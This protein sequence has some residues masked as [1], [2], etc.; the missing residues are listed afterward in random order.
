[1]KHCIRHKSNGTFYYLCQPCPPLHVIYLSPAKQR[2]SCDLYSN[3][4]IIL[5]Y[6]PILHVTIARGNHGQM[7][8]LGMYDVFS[9]LF[10]LVHLLPILDAVD[11]SCLPGTS[12]PLGLKIAF[13]VPVHLK[14]VLL[15][16][17]SLFAVFP[18]SVFPRAASIAF[19]LISHYVLSKQFHQLT[20]LQLSFLCWWLI[21]QA[22][23]QLFFL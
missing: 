9:H 1:M 23:H 2:L 17:M 15:V 4:W 21:N 10:F 12:H 6:F 3:L 7:Y 14:T 13:L 22:Q 11:P 8:G 18:P 5:S 19:F 20:H 16:L